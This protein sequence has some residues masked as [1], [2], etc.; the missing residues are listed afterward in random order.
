MKKKTTKISSM[1]ILVISFISLLVKLKLTSLK[2]SKIK[3]MNML[4]AVRIG[5]GG[6][7]SF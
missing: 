1:Y 4:A 3:Y 6:A 7:V 2:T 5:R